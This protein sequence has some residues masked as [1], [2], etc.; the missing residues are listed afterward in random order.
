MKEVSFPVYRLTNRRPETREGVV[1]YSNTYLDVDT[2]ERSTNIKIVDSLHE[3]GNTLSQRRLQLK[4]RG[5][6]VYPIRVA[7][8][9]LGDF[10]KLA[11]SGY[12][13]IDSLG[14]I[15]TYRKQARA[16]LVYKKIV[17]VVPTQT[18]GSI[19]EVEGESERFKTLFT[20]D[21]LDRYA[22]ILKF[23]QMSILYG[24][25]ATSG[26]PSWRKI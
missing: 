5:A 10:I 2:A 21:P 3:P 15:F 23:G 1:Y 11:H 18:T 8:Y 19:I 9:F 24:T 26:K 16:R 12:W 14:K 17:K 22:A 13:F 6:P 7:V 25:A 4:S 20:V